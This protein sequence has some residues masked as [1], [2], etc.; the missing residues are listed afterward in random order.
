[1]ADGEG[2][3]GEETAAGAGGAEDVDGVWR[4]PSGAAT[5][6]CQRLAAAREIAMLTRVSMAARRRDGIGE[7]GARLMRKGALVLGGRWRRR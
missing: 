6:T 4:H 2:D 1:M 7:D 5:T 3:V